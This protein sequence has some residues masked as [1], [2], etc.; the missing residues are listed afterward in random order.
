MSTLTW[1]DVIVKLLSNEAHLP[2]Q[3]RIQYVGERIRWFFEQQKDA[4]LEFMEGL[5]GTPSARLYSPLYPKHAKMLKQNPMIRHLVFEMFS[6]VTNRQLKQFVELFDNM[7]TSTFSNPW[8]FLKRATTDEENIDESSGD[9]VPEATLPTFDDTKERVPTEIQSR[10]GVEMI[11]SKYIQAIP[12]DPT[13]IDAAVEKVEELV[14]KIYS[15]IRSQ[16]CDQV[17]LFSESFFKLPMLRRLEEDMAEIQLSEADKVNYEARRDSLGAKIKE[18]Q[19]SL[20]EVNWCIDR[21][22]GFKVMCEARR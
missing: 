3:R 22:E 1:R 10:N 9:S 6:E 4:V 20:V 19:D 5:E 7:L 12:D 14:L 13:Q 18:A 8:V 16:V 17:E 21:L 11:L 2:L 15:F